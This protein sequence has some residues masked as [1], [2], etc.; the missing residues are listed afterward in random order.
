MQEKITITVNGVDRHLTID[1]DTPL[2]YALRNDLGITSPRQG[3][4]QEQCGACKVI[5]DG[6][7][8]YAC[9]V[10]VGEATN[11]KITTVEGLSADGVLHPLQ[12]ALIDE[13]AAQCG[14]CLSGIINSAVLLLAKNPSPSRTDIQTALKDHLCRCGAHNRIIKA[15]QRAGREMSHV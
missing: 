2:L 8:A 12:Q 14:Y 7:T 9:T 3:C 5:M 11:R 6:Q 1:A 15:V 10:T 13:N 4:G